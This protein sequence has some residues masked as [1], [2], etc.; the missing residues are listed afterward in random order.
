MVLMICGLYIKGLFEKY[1]H[2]PFGLSDC[3]N[4]GRHLIRR[5]PCA[6]FPTG[7]GAADAAFCFVSDFIT[8]LWSLFLWFVLLFLILKNRIFSLRSSAV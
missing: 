1:N 6:T 7:E 4:F 8:A 3:T 5:T 2:C